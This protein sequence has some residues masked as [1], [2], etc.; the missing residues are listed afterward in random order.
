[1]IERRGIMLSE[2]QAEMWTLDSDRRIVR[3]SV[4]EVPIPGLP[5]PLKVTIEFDARAPSTPCWSNSRSCGCRYCPPASR[6]NGTS[7]FSRAIDH[8]F[9]AAIAAISG[10]V[11]YRILVPPLTPRHFVFFGGLSLFAL[12]LP[13]SEY[14]SAGRDEAQS[15]SLSLELGSVVLQFVRIALKALL[16]GPRTETAC[17]S[18]CPRGDMSIVCRLV[19]QFFGTHDCLLASQPNN[20]ESPEKVTWADPATAI[21]NREEFVV[22][23]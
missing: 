19:F 12:L 9:R 10:P 15:P 23:V 20:A 16:L 22:I 5:Q 21:I 3:L 8:Q 4:P 1:M 17:Q 13:P 11:G 7:T 2:A 18:A 6:G 14:R